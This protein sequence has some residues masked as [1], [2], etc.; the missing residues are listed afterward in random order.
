MRVR[1]VII[2][3]LLSVQSD[4]VHHQKSFL[5][6]EFL[7]NVEK[8]YSEAFLPMIDDICFQV[9]SFDILLDSGLKPWLLNVKVAP[10][11]GEDELGIK[12]GFL[13]NVFDMINVTPQLKTTKI[14][15]YEEMMECQQTQNQDFN[16][17]K[18][19]LQNY[20]KL[21]VK[22]EHKQCDP[23]KFDRIFPLDK[24]QPQ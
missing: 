21:A 9:L 23:T 5:C 8:K 13:R 12:K 11:L 20:L 2:K 15:L 6:Q 16:T 4:L 17:T 22:L 14:N 7:T 3:S 18:L 24:G 1:D 10:D 19:I